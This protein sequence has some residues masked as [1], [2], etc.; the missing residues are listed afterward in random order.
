MTTNKVTVKIT[1]SGLLVLHTRGVQVSTTPVAVSPDWINGNGAKWLID[2]P[3]GLEVTQE[4]TDFKVVLRKEG[5]AE[6]KVVL[7]QGESSTA[8]LVSTEMRN[9]WLT[10]NGMDVPLVESAAQAAVAPPVAAAPAQSDAATQPKSIWKKVAIALAVLVALAALGA[11]GYF[12]VN[13]FNNKHAGAPSL[14]MSGMSL[15]QIAEMDKR[16]DVINGIQE[17][18]F[19]AASFGRAKAKELDGT[20]P[21]EHIELLKSMGLD[22][23]A[24]M[25]SAAACLS[26]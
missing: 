26:K 3:L 12:A 6:S 9:M 8:A 14:D 10:A 20:I 15:E 16:P 5:D 21:D 4:S 24:T 11:G 19:Q 18:M 2:F 13:K 25:K 1:G 22:P 17:Q 7:F 23:G